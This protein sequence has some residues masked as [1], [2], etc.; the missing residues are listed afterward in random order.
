[1]TK[2]ERHAVGHTLWSTLS[3][4]PDLVGGI[5]RFSPIPLTEDQ[6]GTESSLRRMARRMKFSRESVVDRQP[7]SLKQR[8]QRILR[9]LTGGLQGLEQ[10]FLTPEEELQASAA[11]AT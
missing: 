9:A 2:A 8:G 5:Q 7:E 3:M 1:M 10:Y 4:I 6:K 11:K